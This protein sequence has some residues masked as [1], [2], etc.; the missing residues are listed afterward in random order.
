[1]ARPMAVPLKSF[2]VRLIAARRRP[3][4]RKTACPLPAIHCVAI[5]LRPT[6]LK[7]L[8]N[9][10]VSRVLCISCS[11]SNDTLPCSDC[12]HANGGLVII[13]IALSWGFV[14]ITHVLAQETNGLTKSACSRCWRGLYRTQSSSLFFFAVFLFWVQTLL[15]VMS[16]SHSAFNW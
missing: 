6:T 11:K 9:A 15:I 4:A 8:A 2:P 7:S 1:M 13:I 14:L 12:P 3:H 5:A 16:G 10:F